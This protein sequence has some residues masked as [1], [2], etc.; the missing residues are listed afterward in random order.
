MPY[1]VDIALPEADSEDMRRL[2]GVFHQQLKL[3]EMRGP[4]CCLDPEGYRRWC[5]ERME[6]AR[7][8]HAIFGG[9]LVTRLGDAPK[10]G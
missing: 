1:S 3:E 7:S 5:F 4:V 8:F 10:P 6:H 2:I 9:T